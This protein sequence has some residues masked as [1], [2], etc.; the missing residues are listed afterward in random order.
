QGLAMGVSDGSDRAARADAQ[1]V[2][3]VGMLARL[4]EHWDSIETRPIMMEL[5]FEPGV[6][7]SKNKV[8]VAP[9]TP[10]VAP[11]RDRGV[12]TEDGVESYIGLV[13]VTEVFH[14]RVHFLLASGVP[15][16]LAPKRVGFGLPTIGTGLHSGF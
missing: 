12:V 13:L 15:W 5:S 7:G 10:V 3:I 14:P 11:V 1:K 2:E 8:P 4:R 6:R 16:H 9:G